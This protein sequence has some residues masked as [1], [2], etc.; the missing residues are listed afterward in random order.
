MMIA[1]QHDPVVRISFLWRAVFP[2]CG[3]F[4]LEIL[5]TPHALTHI[6][7]LP[8]TPHTLCPPSNILAQDTLGQLKAYQEQPAYRF[9]LPL[10]PRGTPFQQ[11]TWKALC[12]IPCGATTSYGQLASRLHTSP[13][14][15]G[16][17]CR[18]NPYP[19]L[20]PCHRVLTTSGQLGGFSGHRDGFFLAVKAWLLAHEARG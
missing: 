14:A 18:A 20:V 5:G 9:N 1:R 12:D 7:F 17:A 11:K 6:A 16:G 15:V 2:M 8:P 3:I 4:S 19:V 13:R 10:S